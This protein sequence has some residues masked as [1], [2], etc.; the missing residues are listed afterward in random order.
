MKKK[1]KKTIDMDVYYSDISGRKIEEY[2]RHFNQCVRCG[3][4]MTNDEIGD[5]EED[6]SLCKECFDAGYEFDYDSEPG[7]VGIIDKDGN[8]VEAPWM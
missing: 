7:A 1:E 3:K 8:A 5:T 6:G 2:E 4:N